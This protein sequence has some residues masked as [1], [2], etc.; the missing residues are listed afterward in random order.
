[1]MGCNL[2]RFC[3]LGDFIR[4]AQDSMSLDRALHMAG[5]EGYAPAAGAGMN[6][7]NSTA[8]ASC[9]QHEMV[10]D[11]P[12]TISVVLRGLLQGARL[13]TLALPAPILCPSL[14]STESRSLRHQ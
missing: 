10:D 3:K 11:G 7:I 13:A 1:M 2:L 5:G 9:L 8:N 12:A 4:A 14:L 6:S